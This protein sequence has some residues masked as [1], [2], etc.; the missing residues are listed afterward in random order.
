MHIRS[1]RNCPPGLLNTPHSTR[2]HDAGRVGKVRK[3]RE[4]L[5]RLAR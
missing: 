1:W 4:N 5:I 3:G 2:L